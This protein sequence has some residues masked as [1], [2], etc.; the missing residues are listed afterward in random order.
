MNSASDPAG[1][2]GWTMRIFG[3]LAARVIGA[4]SRTGSYETFLYSTELSA[5]VLATIS[6]V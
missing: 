3:A 5:S 1:S 2:A 4:K 6:S